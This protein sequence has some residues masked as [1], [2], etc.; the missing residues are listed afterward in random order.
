MKYKELKHFLINEMRMS[1]IYQPV[2]IKALLRHGGKGD[3][4]LIA[5]H[6]LAWDESQKEYYEQVTRNM[7][8]KVLTKNRGITDKEGDTYILR[9]FDSLSKEH[10]KELEQICDAKIDEYIEKRGKKIWSHR[11][12]S[13]DAI[14]G[15]VRYEVLKRAKSKCELCGISSKE[16]SLDIDHI[17][18]RTKGGTND[19]S[20]LQALC[21][22]CNRQKNNKDDTDFR[23][24]A[25]TFDYREKDC[26]FCDPKRTLLDENAYAIAFKD[27]YP[28]TKGHAL[29]IPKRHVE[30]Y[31]DLTQSEL[32][33]M[34]QIAKSLKDKLQQKDKSITGFNIGFN[35]GESAGQTV[36]HAHMHLIPRRQGD[37]SSPRGGIR[38]II[39]DK[40]HY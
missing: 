32:N 12:F 40:Q 1:H 7:V 20:N 27:N 36:F 28:V 22:T 17:I 2:M 19:I 13:N 31:F 8:G 38:G 35:A 33:A 9:D 26:I 3:T 6:L 29:I 11:Q 18:P 37:V 24:I 4:Q 39:P 5:K 21:Y 34:N 14:S 30:T 23:G 10:I 15:S 25:A 16:K